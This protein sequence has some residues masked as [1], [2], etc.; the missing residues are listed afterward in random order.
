MKKQDCFQIGII[1]KTH[2][3]HG[4]LI[5]E[6]TSPDLA[7]NIKES[8]LVEIDGLLVPF[9]IKQ[10]KQTSPQRLRVLLDWVSTN[11]QAKKLTNCAIFLPSDKITF[12]EI[13]IDENLDIL[14]GFMVIDTI[15]GELGN[16]DY[17]IDDKLNP[18]MSVTY[19]KSEVLIPVN[20][21][22]I[23]NINPENRTITI[24]SPKGL[25][26][27]YTNPESNEITG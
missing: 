13:D 21:D 20:P 11:N 9:F 18:I 27:L 14:T 8:I 23:V 12:Q 5:F 15:F 25:I 17:I 1:I 3:I 16:I 26:D 24:D 7:E 10:I 4:E 19:K 2:G 6:I 22:L